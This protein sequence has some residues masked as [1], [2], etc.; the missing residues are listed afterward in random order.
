MLDLGFEPQAMFIVDSVLPDQ[1]TV[2]FSATFPKQMQ[3]SA[4]L[5]L[6]KPIEI[7]VGSNKGVCSDVTLETVIF[8]FLKIFWI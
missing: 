1:Q 2:M 5:I 4:K 3:I 8:I 6:H 7:S